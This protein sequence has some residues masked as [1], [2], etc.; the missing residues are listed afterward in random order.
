MLTTLAAGGSPIL[1]K[2][3]RVLVRELE[4][5]AILL[6]LETETYFGLDA[7]GTRIWA[8]LLRKP[9]VDAACE[10]LLEALDVEP[11]VLRRDV[12]GLVAELVEAGLLE[13][14]AA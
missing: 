11:A 4:G 5:E 1:R 6:D 7:V 13:R 8:E 9:S 12:E 10:A 2:P 3:D 14:R